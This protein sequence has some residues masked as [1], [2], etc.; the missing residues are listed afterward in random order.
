MEGAVGASARQVAA[1]AE[2]AKLK[3]KVLL[4]SEEVCWPVV[5]PAA[6][7]EGS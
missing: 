1:H 3:I 4:E 6:E 7:E 5:A 2:A